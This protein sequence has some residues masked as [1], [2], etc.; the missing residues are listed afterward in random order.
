M[1][2]PVQERPTDQTKVYPDAMRKDVEIWTT[3]IEIQGD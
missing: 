3:S 2:Y 1:K